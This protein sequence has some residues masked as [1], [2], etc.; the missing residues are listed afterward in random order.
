MAHTPRDSDSG[1]SFN[2]PPY[3]SARLRAGRNKSGMSLR[4]LARSVDLSP[5]LISQIET[6]K[7]NPSVGTLVALATALEIPLDELF[8][9]ELENAAADGGTETV[10]RPSRGSSTQNPI[11]RARDR[12]SVDLAGGVRWERLTPSTDSKVSFLYVTYGVGGS[13]SPPGA[14]MQ[15][16][17]RE[18]GLV[19]EGR[20]GAQI[21]AESHDLGP[22]DSIVFDCSTPH[23]FWTIG[24][25]PAVVV[26]TVVGPAD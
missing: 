18:F 23:R 1:E 4:A 11:L 24:D 13:S 25:R 2:L 6:G 7:V 17:G 5:S 16:E 9:D 15:H 8:S 21:G 10:S 3:V 12:R 20:L 26:W 22:G 19:L 14:L